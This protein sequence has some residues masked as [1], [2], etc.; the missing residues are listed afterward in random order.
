[1]GQNLDFLRPGA[2]TALREGTLFQCKVNHG[3]RREHDLAEPKGRGGKTVKLSSQMHL[4]IKL[5]LRVGGG[6][7][8]KRRRQEGWTQCKRLKFRFQ[9][10]PWPLQIHPHMILNCYQCCKIDSSIFPNNQFTF[11][12]T[13]M[14]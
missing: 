4:D 11:S 14:F 13:Q 3:V 8:G 9:K 6:L 1:M 2:R 5:G 10:W 12:I 7:L